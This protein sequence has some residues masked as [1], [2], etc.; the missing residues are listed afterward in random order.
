MVVL[1]RVGHMP[2]NGEDEKDAA[3]VF[4][5]GATKATQRLVMGDLGMRLGITRQ[6]N[7]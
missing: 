5:V 2:A 7:H 4:Y 3:R 1:T 6:I